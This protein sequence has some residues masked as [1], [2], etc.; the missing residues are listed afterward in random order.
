MSQPLVKPLQ[1]KIREPQKPKHA[2]KAEQS[3]ERAQTTMPQQPKQMPQ[4]KCAT[5]LIN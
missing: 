3:Q 1:V 4:P 2:R 5:K